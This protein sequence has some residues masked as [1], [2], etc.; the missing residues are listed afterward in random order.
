MAVVVVNYIRNGK[1]VR[2]KAKATLSYICHRVGQDKEK[3]SR[4][5]FS[6]GGELQEDQAARI[7]DEAPKGTRFWRM[8]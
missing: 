3:M 7:I 6:W 4:T 2:G 5:L 8:M 1:N